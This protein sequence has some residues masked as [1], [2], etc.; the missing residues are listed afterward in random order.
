MT[1]DM[2]GLDVLLQEYKQPGGGVR[3]LGPWLKQAAPCYEFVSIAAQAERRS[4][5]CQIQPRIET[6]YQL[7]TALAR[8]RL[9]AW[10]GVH[11]V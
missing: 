2:A 4:I 11:H 3:D 8:P 7:L 10:E 1:A 9:Q 5:M 6:A